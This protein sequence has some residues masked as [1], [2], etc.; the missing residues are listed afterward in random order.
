MV[1]AVGGLYQLLL[2]IGFLALGRALQPAESDDTCRPLQADT[3]VMLEVDFGAC[4]CVGTL[5]GL[6]PFAALRLAITRVR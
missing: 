6:A 1:F 4:T 3:N 5:V 2:L